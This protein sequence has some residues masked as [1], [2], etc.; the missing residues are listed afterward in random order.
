MTN[1]I[2]YYK[3][4]RDYYLRKDPKY[5]SHIA[6]IELHDRITNRID[7]SAGDYSYSISITRKDII[8]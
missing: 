5:K 6:E 7:A 1:P 4:D 2:K 3:S 8:P